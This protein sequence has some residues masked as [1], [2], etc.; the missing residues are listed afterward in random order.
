MAQASGILPPPVAP[1]A[2]PPDFGNGG[3]TS[4][5]DAFSAVATDTNLLLKMY[6]DTG[7]AVRD[8]AYWP[9][10]TTTTSNPGAYSPGV[11]NS[12]FTPRIDLFGS[13]DVNKLSFLT[14]VMFEG[15]HN[16]LSVDLERVQLTYLVSNWLRLRAGRTHLA[17]G[18]YN[19]TYHH[20]NLFELTTSRPYSV[21]FEDSGGIILAH[22][23][24]VG[25]DGTLGDGLASFR[26]DVEVGNGHGADVTAVSLQYAEK[27]QK[28]VNV[29]F[30]WMPVDGLII[31][32]NGMRDVI[33]TLLSTAMGVP[34]RPDTEELVAGAH[35]VYTEH[36]FIVDFEGFAMRHNPSGA[37][38]DDIFGGFAEVGYTIG[39]FTPYL[40]PEYIRF[41]A[42]PDVIYQY[43]ADDAQGI[44][45]G[46]P[47]PYTATRDFADLRLGLKW[48]PVPQLAF[49]LEVERLS[50]DSHAQDI[51]TAKA[52]FG[53]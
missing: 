2:P 42:S 33:P 29:R 4:F 51:A 16:E 30:R 41:P 14:E 46:G 39:A 49:K 3:T 17:W 6:G 15:N 36:S 10:A 38:S 32:I 20:G 53:F 52:A 45:S 5:G 23:V 24:G 7:F 13:A 8:N 12:F 22:N 35:V 34:S 48:A 19:D 25:A 40:R 21:Q 11:W 9:W 28:S 37:P 27:N 50:H 26:Y 44:A 1:A 43:S 31:G 18:Y 47:S